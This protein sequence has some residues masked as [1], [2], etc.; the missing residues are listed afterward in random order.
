[1][2]TYIARTYAEAAG[3]HDGRITLLVILCNPQPD[4]AA[5]FSGCDKPEP[6]ILREGSPVYYDPL[7]YAPYAPGDVI[8]VRVPGSSIIG[9]GPRLLVKSCE[10]RQVQSITPLEFRNLGF[11]P[12]ALRDALG[13]LADKVRREDLYWIHGVDDPGCW[14]NKCASKEVKRLIAAGADPDEVC[15]DGGWGGDEDGNESCQGCGVDL[16]CFLTEYGV[17]EEVEH[18][19]QYPIECNHDAYCMWH[20]LDSDE[21]NHSMLDPTSEHHDAELYDAVTL[22]A[23]H[24]LWDRRHP[25]HP[26]ASN[27]W[28]FFTTVKLETS[29]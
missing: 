17:E 4:G 21:A 28:T 12:N 5:R 14:C 10:A 1:M 26:W 23:A 27:P 6:Y 19:A 29:K 7:K 16:E 25:K 20:A 13:P 22:I 9:D 8:V 11:T 2:K 24:Y 3:L 18:F 15:V